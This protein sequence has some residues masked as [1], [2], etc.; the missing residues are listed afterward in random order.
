M[1]ISLALAIVIIIIT[2]E[3]E[4]RI[5]DVVFYGRGLFDTVHLIISI[6]AD[7]GFDS[8]ITANHKKSVFDNNDPMAIPR[9]S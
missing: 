5:V 7:F 4:F 9:A 8:S 3:A 1:Q 6:V 2:D